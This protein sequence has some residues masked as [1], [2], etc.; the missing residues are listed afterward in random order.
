M[1]S[2][3]LDSNI[4]MYARLPDYDGLRGFL[5]DYRFHVSKIKNS[6]NNPMNGNIKIRHYLFEVKKFADGNTE[7]ATIIDRLEGGEC[8]DR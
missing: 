2:A 7:F 8:V 5:A 4:I 3:I 1:N 6:L